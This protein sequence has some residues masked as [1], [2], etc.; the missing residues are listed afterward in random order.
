MSYNSFNNKWIDEFNSKLLEIKSNYIDVIECNL[1]V[2]K[3]YSQLY[4]FVNS[5]KEKEY[6]IANNI[7]FLKENIFSDDTLINLFSY[8]MN[9]N[10]IVKDDTM[11]NIVINQWCIVNKYVKRKEYLLLYEKG[12]YIP[13][14]LK[15]YPLIKYNELVKKN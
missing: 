13:S 9:K 4:L 1:N 6:I 12:G 10:I 3:L 14:L 11:K 5:E 8:I 7:L 2:F 15:E